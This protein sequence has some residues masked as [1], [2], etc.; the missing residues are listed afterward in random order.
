MI[1]A[2]LPLGGALDPRASVG[3]YAGITGVFVN[4][5]EIHPER[6]AQAV[7]GVAISVDLVMMRLDRPF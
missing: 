5:R 1:A 7:R 2:G 4:G 3:R 6:P